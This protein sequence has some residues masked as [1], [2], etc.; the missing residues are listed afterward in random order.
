MTPLHCI[1]QAGIQKNKI[2]IMHP[3]N[4]LLQYGADVTV[5]NEWEATPFFQAVYDITIKSNERSTEDNNPILLDIE[6]EMIQLLFE[7]NND[8][9]NTPLGVPD[10]FDSDYGGCDNYDTPLHCAIKY[11]NIPMTS[12]LLSLGASVTIPNDNGFTPFYQLIFDICKYSADVN[13][14]PDDEM[15]LFHLLV[16]TSDINMKLKLCDGAEMQSYSTLYHLY[17]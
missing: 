7:L 16:S 4:L 13:V 6:K 1:I 8:V 9:I 17:G 11:K 15:S 3:I 5:P 10:G 14:I 12:F 2:D